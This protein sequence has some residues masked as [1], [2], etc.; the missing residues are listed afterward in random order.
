MQFNDMN[1]NRNLF[2]RETQESFPALGQPSS[3]RQT[4]RASF[5]PSQLSVRSK[6]VS[7]SITIKICLIISALPKSYIKK[8]LF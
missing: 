7:N 8:H 4:T 6:T 1:S 3:R 2:S 5:Q